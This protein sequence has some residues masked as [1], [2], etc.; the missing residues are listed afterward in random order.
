MI[1]DTAF[2][3][4][5]WIGLGGEI[6]GQTDITSLICAH[7][8]CIAVVRTLETSSLENSTWRHLK[9]NIICCKKKKDSCA[10]DLLRLCG[11][12]MNLEVSAVYIV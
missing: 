8:S 10:A 3:L 9:L 11:T 2:Y 7:F 1:S 5:S 12:L 6:S 4:N